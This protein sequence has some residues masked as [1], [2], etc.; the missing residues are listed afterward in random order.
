MD[1]LSQ[2]KSLIRILI[3]M[4]VLNLTLIVYIGWKVFA[5]KGKGNEPILQPKE[6]SEF[7][8]KELQLT[9]NQA[10]SL[11]K[12][13][14]NFFEKETLLTTETRAKRD[15]MNMLMFNENIND[16]LLRK[17]AES[18]AAN[19]YKMEELRINQA[20]QF[21]NLLTTHQNKNLN[22]LVKEIRDY[23]KPENIHKN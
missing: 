9:N 18:V 14:A 16:S 15:S 22:K 6:L 2:K 7:L 1:I 12:I 13:R 5:H 21:R 19:E 11:Q 20:I 3:L 23:L 8:K 10:D 4:V 17:L